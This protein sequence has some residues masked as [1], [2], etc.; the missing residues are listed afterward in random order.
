MFKY[1]YSIQILV[2][3]LLFPLVSIAGTLTGKI[4]DEKGEL[5]PFAVVYVKGTTTGATANASAEYQLELQPGKYEVSCQYIGYQ[6]TT[7]TVTV[8][9][10]EKLTHNFVLKEQSLQM[11]NVVVSANAEDPAYAIMRKAIAKR[12][13]H[14]DQVNTF[15]SSIYMKGVARNR[16]L[17][18]KIFGIKVE[19]EDVAQSGGGGA[20]S[21]SLGV[22]YLFEQEADYYKEGNKER[23]IVKSVRESGNPNGVGLARVPP[24]V[25]F[26]DN[27]VN[28]LFGL[29]E[30]GFI[31]PVSDGA[32]GYYRYKYEGEFI[33]D[34]Y[35]INKIK[36]T[37][38]RAY[39]PLFDGYIYI[40]DKDWAIHSLNLLLTKKANLESFDT[41][42]IE[43]T[44]LPLK[45]DTWIIKSQVQYPTV[46]FLGIGITANIVAVYDDQKINEHIP[47]SLFNNRVISSYRKDANDKDSSY[48]DKARAVPLEDDEVEDFEIKDSVRKVFTSPEYRDSMRRLGNKFNILNLLI[49]GY[50]YNSK[51]RKN[52]F[53]MNSVLGGMVTYNTIEGIA[54][55]PQFE[56]RHAIDTGKVLGTTIGTRYGFSNT[57]LNIFGKISYSNYD[58]TWIGRM[59][60][61]GVEGGKYVFQYNQKSSVTPLYNTFSTLFYGKNY[62]KIYERWTAAVFARRVYGNGLSWNAKAGFQRR[63]PLSN[64][65]FYTWAKNDPEKWTGNVPANL[66]GNPW[67]VHNAALVKVSVSYR[68]GYSYVQYPKFKSPRQ[69][70]WPLFT[71]TYE[72]GIPGLLDSKVDF[73]KWRFEIEDYMNMKLLG[74]IEY[75]IAAGGFLNSKFVSLPDMMHITDNQLSVA[76]PYLRSFQMAPYYLFS[77]T[78]KLYGELHLEYNMNGLFTNKL[79]LFRQAR[80]NFVAGTNT[81]YID[82]ANYYTEAFLG[83][84]NI[85]YKFI[86]F[87]RVDVVHSWSSKNPQST[88]VRLGFDLNSLRASG[89]VVVNDNVENFDW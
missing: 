44:Y 60:E 73:D 81:L 70:K 4:T 34:G 11:K 88:G 86:R 82:Q 10:S 75:N 27:N 18:S 56:L 83:V 61:L 3:I 64:T 47:D 46:D 42:R 25:S 1:R 68:P 28:P 35:T 9:G 52:T 13:F 20:D 79:P 49:D 54:L 84:D 17:P 7:F 67:G 12:K 21:N 55:L 19:G 8:H 16:K 38:R 89:G 74:S 76:A 22:I 39:E 14:K 78:A 40:V 65:V 58:R 24:V 50:S 51:N 85:G 5:L 30:R 43:Q 33:Q 41:L 53:Y 15:R 66:S 62:L 69:G 6:Q 80:W 87:L 29:S 71:L 57:H 45:K 72:K 32:M 77:N 36:V 37:P 31:S 23:T 59:W 2:I 48:W 26:Y 63:L